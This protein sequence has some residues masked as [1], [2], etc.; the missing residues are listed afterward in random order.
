M[1]GRKALQL[2]S[3]LVLVV[4]SLFLLVTFIYLLEVTSH[5][6]FPRF[7][8]YMVLSVV[9]V[10]TVLGVLWVLTSGVAVC[11]TRSWLT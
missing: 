9:G 4:L 2:I 10:I 3:G 1:N 8:I 5:A 11:G 6:E 7:I